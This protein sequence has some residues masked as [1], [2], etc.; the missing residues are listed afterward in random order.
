MEMLDLQPFE[1]GTMDGWVEKWNELNDTFHQKVLSVLV[2]DPDNEMRIAEMTND[3]GKL[4]K[5]F[6]LS[7]C[8]DGDYKLMLNA[9]SVGYEGIMFDNADSVP[10]I[11]DKGK[12]EE[13]VRFSL[14]RESDFPLPNGDTFD[15]NDLAIAVRC[16]K[17]PQYLNGKSLQ[18]LIIDMKK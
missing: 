7:Q 4:L 17:Y 6:D 5:Y 16:S 1:D 2:I 9:L 13:L 11:S 15:F 10:D 14:K 8:A 3:E 12:I 18:S